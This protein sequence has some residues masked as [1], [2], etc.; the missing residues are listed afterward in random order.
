MSVAAVMSMMDM[1]APMATV[2]MGTPSV[3]AAATATYLLYEIIF[4]L[5]RLGEP[6]GRVWY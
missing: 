1:T 2:G 3:P 4:G 6:T 5:S